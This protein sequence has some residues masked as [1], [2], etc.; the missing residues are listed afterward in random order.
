MQYLVA[1]T[2]AQAIALIANGG[3]P[4][5][6]GTTLVPRIQNETPPDTIVDITKIG[7]LRTVQNS[8]KV[9]QLG[10]V[11]TLE[12]AAETLSAHRSL[13]AALAAVRTIGNPHIRRLATLGGNI[14][15]DKE[16]QTGDLTTAL[17]ALDGR[18][19]V[20][21]TEGLDEMAIGAFLVNGGPGPRLVT[22]IA[23]PID[24]ERRSSFAKFAWRQTSAPAVLSA[25]AAA[26]VVGG[27]LYEARIAIGATTKIP[28]RVSSAEAVLEGQ[29]LDATR[30]AEAAKECARRTP[31]DRFGFAT[32]DYVHSAVQQVMHD[33]ISEL[34]AGPQ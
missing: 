34:G 16:K 25:A 6:G 27:R 28:I 3:V 15:A 21:H 19:T 22:K 33:V 31:I 12:Q 18:V 32:P 26:R 7:D 20:A 23:I 5:A 13:G 9:I 17:L 8:G 2:I 11:V 24:P 14:C 10:A 4:L 1:D 30:I 29:T